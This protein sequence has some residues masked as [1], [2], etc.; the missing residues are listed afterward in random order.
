MS[1]DPF[2]EREN[3]KQID[4]VLE[5]AKKGD[6]FFIFTFAE[7]LYNGTFLD[8]DI[9]EAARWYKLAADEGHAGAL[10]K[11]REMFVKGEIAEYYNPPPYVPPKKKSSTSF[12]GGRKT[13]KS[14]KKSY[15]GNFAS[16]IDEEI[17]AGIFHDDKDDD[18]ESLDFFEYKDDQ[19][20]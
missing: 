15:D 10:E 19:Y 14:R 16:S 8:K 17:V 9:N 12:F 7:Y 5:R 1:K 3:Q 6:V 20:D 2:W 11:L 18:E 13:K 4:F